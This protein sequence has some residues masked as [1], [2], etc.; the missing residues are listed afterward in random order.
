MKVT[1]NQITE[2]GDSFTKKGLISSSKR[3][4]KAVVDK[5]NKVMI[6]SADKQKKTR[7]I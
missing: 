7:S 2:K 4:K 5:G 1:V 6:Q 3:S